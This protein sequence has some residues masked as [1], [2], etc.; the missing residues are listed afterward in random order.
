LLAISRARL[1]AIV[2]PI[3][4]GRHDYGHAAILVEDLHTRAWKLLAAIPA[5]ALSLATAGE[6][7]AI[8]YVSHQATSTAEAGETKVA[9]YNGQTGRRLFRVTAAL[10]ARQA[11]PPNTAVDD[12]GDVLVTET[13]R[14]P[15][16]STRASSGWWAS[17]GRPVAHELRRLITT[18][19]TIPKTNL[20]Y[21]ATLRAAAAVSHGR[22]AYA[23]GDSYEGETIQVLNLHN[24]R[25]RTVVS[26]QGEAGLL[27]LDLADDELAWAQQNTVPVG[28]SESVAGGRSFSCQIVSLGDAK[29]MRI[30]LRSLPASGVT[31]GK[32]LP[33]VDQP[34][35]TSRES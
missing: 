2:D 19:Q 22:I 33:A 7:I 31:V 12:L 3:C 29:L 14:R 6:R 32:P 15:P 16:P 11:T 25:K 17:P 5:G 34:P 9:V 26:L 27:G 8:T 4:L 23:T 10:A 28:H 35:C 30:R 20:G 18:E 24:E 21:E 1:F 13:V